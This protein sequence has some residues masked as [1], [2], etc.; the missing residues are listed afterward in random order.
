[1]KTQLLDAQRL[2]AQPG[3]MPGG[4]LG[5]LTAREF[6]A[7]FWQKRPL[8]VRQAVPGFSGVTDRAGLFR[9]AAREAVESRL[10]RRVGARWSL[11]HGP[12]SAGQL[13]R[14]PAR[15]WTLLV[16]GVNLHLAAA[17]RLLR[18]FDFIPHARLDDLMV[19]HAAPGGGVGPHLDSYDVFLLQ[20]SGSRVWRIARPRGTTARALV[21]GAPLKILRCFE[22]EDEYLLEPGDMLYLPPGWAHEGIALDAGITCSVGFRAPSRRE[23]VAEFLQRYAERVDAR[24]AMAG[25][26]ADPGLRPQRH[27]AQVP[28][29]MLAQTHRLLSRLRFT[30]ARVAGFLGEYLS[31]PKATVVFDPPR[32]PLPPGRFAERIGR[33]GVRL[34]LR[35]I[36][37]VDGNSA[38]VNG[39]RVTPA[40]SVM[41]ALRT[42]ADTRSLAPRRNGAGLRELLYAWYA[43]GWLHPGQIEAV[44]SLAT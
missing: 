15:N 29:S 38:Y 19:S 26:Y 11:L 35:T 37:L 31:E 14:M 8:L 21:E 9:L 7:R 39:E 23:L 33:A 2:D 17:D 13:R 16:Q 3:G 32:R 20:A 12:L 10:V 44:D 36:M 5:G 34:D 27:A 18:R 30:R 6:L 41:K 4:L 42:L 1:M 22:P 25:L 28:A 43:A 40:V 24:G